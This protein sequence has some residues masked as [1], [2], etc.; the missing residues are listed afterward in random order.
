LTRSDTSAKQVAS[1]PWGRPEFV[2][3]S[4]VIT[5]IWALAFAVMVIAELAM[6]YMPSV[7]TARRHCRSDHLP[8][9]RH[10]IRYVIRKERCS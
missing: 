2:G 5:A 4:Y 8:E 9:C 10:R 3:T 1:E 6:L 7:A